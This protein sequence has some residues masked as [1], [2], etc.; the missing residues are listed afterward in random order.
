MQAGVFHG[1][2]LSVGRFLGTQVVKAAAMPSIRVAERLSG[3]KMNFNS[4]RVLNNFILKT[5]L[6]RAPFRGD[7]P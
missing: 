7:V 5:L 1:S 2:W 3:K 6:K 4:Y